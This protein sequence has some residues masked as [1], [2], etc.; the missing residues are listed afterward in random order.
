MLIPDL[1]VSSKALTYR[2]DLNLRPETW[3]K[4]PLAQDAVLKPRLGSCSA[5]GV[6]CI[7]WNFTEVDLC[8][9]AAVQ[10]E[11]Q[12][13]GAPFCEYAL[14]VRF[15]CMVEILKGKARFVLQSLTYVLLMLT[16]SFNYITESL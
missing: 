13:P 9:R 8:H 12:S 1:A 3:A 2:W 7:T 14:L 10:I 16:G 11:S 6:T 5:D 15:L 4:A